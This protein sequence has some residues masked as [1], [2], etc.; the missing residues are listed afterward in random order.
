MAARR[1]SE[2]FKRDAVE[3][4]ASTGRSVNTPARQGD[5]KVPD[6]LASAQATTV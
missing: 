2:E 5:C 6:D 3:L 1:Y 4:V